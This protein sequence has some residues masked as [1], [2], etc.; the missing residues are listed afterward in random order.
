MSFPVRTDLKTNIQEQ[1]PECKKGEARENAAE[2]FNTNPR[3]VSDAKKIQ[4][5]APKKAEE[6]LQPQNERGPS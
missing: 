2:D 5:E 6:F 3:Y 4:K 1:I